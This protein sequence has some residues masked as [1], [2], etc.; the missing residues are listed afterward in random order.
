MRPRRVVWLRLLDTHHADCILDIP[1]NRRASS[2]FNTIT[3]PLVVHLGCQ[4]RFYV[5]SRHLNLLCHAKRSQ[6]V[7]VVI[8]IWVGQN[9]ARTSVH[10]VAVISANLERIERSTAKLGS[11]PAAPHFDWHKVASGTKF[12]RYLLGICREISRCLSPVT[13]LLNN[14]KRELS[15]A[16]P[17]SRRLGTGTKPDNPYV[18]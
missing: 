7:P 11:R 12:S 1:R 6:S 17:T 5:G 8:D 4:F 10:L 9:T 16:I 2:I 14:P 18:V 3:A 15:I 13:S